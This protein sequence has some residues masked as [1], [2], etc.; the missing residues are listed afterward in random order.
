MIDFQKI[1]NSIRT[2]TG[3][4]DYEIA[5]RLNQKG[6]IVHQPTINRI[7]NGH[8]TKDTSRLSR[9]YVLG[10]RIMELEKHAKRTAN[11]ENDSRLSRD[12]E[13]STLGTD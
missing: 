8:V 12:N 10:S 11:S 4:S 13:E 7:R 2:L 6:H 1:L 5:R 3:W 9:G